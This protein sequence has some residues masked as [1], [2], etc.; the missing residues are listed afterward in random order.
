MILAGN[1][2]CT[3]EKTDGYRIFVQKSE[4]NRPQG[5]PWRRLEITLKWILKRDR[6]VGMDWIDVA[7]DRDLWRTLVN[8]VMNLRTP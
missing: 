8:T 4:G 2:A 5:R 1:V 3:G 7:Q 6:W